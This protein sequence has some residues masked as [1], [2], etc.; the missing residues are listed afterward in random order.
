MIVRDDSKTLAGYVALL[1]HPAMALSGDDAQAATQLQGLA[2]RL[3]G[4]VA[5][6]A[7]TQA[8][9]AGWQAHFQSVIASALA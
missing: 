2:E 4:Q 1:G 9:L 7:A 3:S 5:D 8:T 6:R